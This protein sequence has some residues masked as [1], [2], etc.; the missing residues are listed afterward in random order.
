MP[1]YAGLKRIQDDAM[2]RRTID[3]LKRLRMALGTGIPARTAT[4]TL[5]LATW[6]I[7]EF[8]SGKYGYRPAEPYYYIAEI[9]SRFDLIAI[10]EVRD[11]LYPLQE[12]VRI[13]VS[14]INGCAFCVDMHCHDAQKAGETDE[15][16][17]AI[18]TG[19]EAP[20]F[21]AEE[22]AALEL[23]EAATRIADRPDAV[24]DDV[25]DAA[26]DHFDESQLGTLVMTIAAINAWN[27][28]NVINR[29]P[30][31]SYR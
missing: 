25:W 3:G 18:A 2:R 28:I 31:G 30:A 22:R 5:L 14:Q 21:T 16:L 13:R 8:D 26:A 19:R 24:P 1:Y 11:G 29:T 17:F 27:R 7:R 23:A 9:L 10:Q 15:R 20:F 6:N 4:G 12:L